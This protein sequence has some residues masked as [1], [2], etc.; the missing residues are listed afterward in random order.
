MLSSDSILGQF[1][2]DHPLFTFERAKSIRD[3]LFTSEYK[4]E[5]HVNT[6]AHI[7]AVP[8]IIVNICTLPETLFSLMAKYLVPD[9]LLTEKPTMLVTCFAAIPAVSI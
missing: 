5:A 9:I 1:V 7:C 4:G 8:A 6:K 3:R 2:P